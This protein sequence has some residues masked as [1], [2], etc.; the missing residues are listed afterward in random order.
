MDDAV[1]TGVSTAPVEDGSYIKSV[2]EAFADLSEAR[3]ASA[4]W[5]VRIPPLSPGQHV[6]ELF[7]RIDGDPFRATFHITV[8]RGRQ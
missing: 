6:V 8:Q 5:V 1:S 2:D 7:D 3:V 4:G